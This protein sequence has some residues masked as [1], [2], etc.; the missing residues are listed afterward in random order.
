ML[1]RMTAR[2]DFTIEADDGQTVATRWW[3]PEGTPRGLVQIV[4]GMAEHCLRYDRVARR[5]NDAGW[6]VIAH[7]HRGHGETASPD[8]LGHYADDDGLRRVIADMR[9]VR[10]EG[11]ERQ[12]D[13]ALVLLGHSMGSFLSLFD[14]CDAPGSIDA[15]V[16]SGS[17]ELGGPL[18]K[19]GRAAAKLE[20]L[21]QGKRGKSGALAYLSFGSFNKAFEPVRTE[22][23]WLSRDPDEVD[24]YIADPL[25]GFRCTN[26]LWIDFLGALD[27]LGRPD[28][29]G[30]LPASLPVHLMA[31]EQDPVGG[32]KGVTALEG[33]LRA[34]GLRS[35]TRK[36]Y[37]GGR[38]EMFNETN[39]DEVLSDL[40]A[41]LESL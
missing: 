12:A 33:Q 20:R 8:D 16:L 22:F 11:R 5:L 26:Q 34:A 7:D 37:P 18:V 31:G 10:R 35:L 36:I 29:R 17:N 4:H 41:V 24:A 40:I 27:R 3:S 13:G 38:H 30:R 32:E 23:D 28:F 1:P 19:A 39:R 9:R 14:Q 6:A 25:C 15:L 2:E 21:R